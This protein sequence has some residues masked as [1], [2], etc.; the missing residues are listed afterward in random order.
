MKELVKRW[1]S[2]TPQFWKKVQKIGLI[3][4]GIAGVITT[5]PVT[6]PTIIVSIAGYLTVA[7]GTIAAISQ[8]AVEDSSK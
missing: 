4:G 3:F 7:S 2:P 1:K 8:L 6:L 5:S